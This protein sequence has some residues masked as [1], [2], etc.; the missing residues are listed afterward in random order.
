M[1]TVSNP[2][3]AGAQ[4][5]RVV[6]PLRDARRPLHDGLSA[7]HLA[8]EAVAT[9]EPAVAFK[10]L[11]RALAFLQR[12]FLPSCEAEEFTLFIAVDGVYGATGAVAVMRAQHQVM[13]EMTADLEKV[14][15]AAKPGND[16]AAYARLL[17][18]LLFGLYGLARGHLESEDA[19]YLT[20]LDEHLSESQVGVIVDNLD[21][22]AS[23]RRAPAR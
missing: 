10:A 12:T 21:R 15:A 14:V 5:D 23:A 11:D 3:D 16:P 17:H 4:K 8:A 2:V 9:A 19:A 6:G 13:V 22:I 18:P 1:E 7:L 20:V